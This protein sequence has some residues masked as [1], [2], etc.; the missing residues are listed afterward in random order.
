LK[1][2]YVLSMVRDMTAKIRAVAETEGA[3]ES[4]QHIKIV[5]DIVKLIGS[6]Q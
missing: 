2:R 6:N 1:R 3:T 5:Q 4:W